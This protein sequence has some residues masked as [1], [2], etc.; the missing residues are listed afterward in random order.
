MN[1]YIH[2]Y[3]HFPNTVHETYI[4][5]ASVINKYNSCLYILCKSVCVWLLK[6]IISLTLI[7]F[8]SKML[9]GYIKISC[10]CSILKV[11]LPA[12]FYIFCSFAPFIKEELPACFYIFCFTA[13]FLKVTSPAYFYISCFTA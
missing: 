4:F 7:L 5:S 8:N 13:P 1:L 9:L 6:D 10:Q 3:P 11:A 12:Y 2:C